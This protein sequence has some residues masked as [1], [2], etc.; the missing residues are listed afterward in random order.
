MIA[1]IIFVPL[2][3]ATIG[4]ISHTLFPFLP[5]ASPIA[6]SPSPAAVSPTPATLSEQLTFTGLLRGKMTTADNAGAFAHSHPGVMGEDFPTQTLCAMWSDD[7]S[8]WFWQADII[9]TVN[10]KT[11]ALQLRYSWGFYHPPGSPPTTFPVDVEDNIGAQVD[12]WNGSPGEVVFVSW[13]FGS[14]GSFTVAS[15]MSHG[16]IDVFLPGVDASGN[17]GP[18]VHVTGQWRCA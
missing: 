5:S 15:D 12:L 2:S 10:G 4:G 14:R 16:T 17:Y 11:W 9:G 7:P 6:Y 3:I 18:L 1:L 13:T 8:F